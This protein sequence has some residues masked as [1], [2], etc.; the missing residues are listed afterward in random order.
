MEYPVPMNFTASTDLYVF[1]CKPLAP[2]RTNITVKWRK[3]R[4]LA[5]LEAFMERPEEAVTHIIDSADGIFTVSGNGQNLTVNNT[6]DSGA[7]SVAF[8]YVPSFQMDGSAEMLTAET[9]IFSEFSSN[10][11]IGFS[12]YAAY[13]YWSGQPC[14]QTNHMSLV[15]GC[16]VDDIYWSGQPCLRNQSHVPCW[17][18]CS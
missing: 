8:Y 9:F 3:F 7:E 10:S 18:L 15:G 11:G 6:V 5:D 13:K 17:W 12:L 16:A 1:T 2:N 14:L 4:L